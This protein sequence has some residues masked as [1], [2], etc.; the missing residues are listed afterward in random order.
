MDEHSNFKYF[1]L[2]EPLCA[3]KFADIIKT[4][5]GKIGLLEGWGG[6]YMMELIPVGITGVMPGL[7][8]SDILQKVFT[9]RKNGENEKAFDLFEKVMP[10]IFFSLQNME[11]FHYVEKE[12]LIARGVLT[13][14]VVRKATY[15]PDASTKAYIKELNNRIL[16]LVNEISNKDF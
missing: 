3:P 4:T 2:E 14:S 8:V 6:L 7:A 5:E 11:L 12:L 15:T 13:N 16:R 9:L 1:K 10:Q